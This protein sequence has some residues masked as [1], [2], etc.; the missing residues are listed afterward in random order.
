MGTIQEAV[1]PK[2]VSLETPTKN[3]LPK[4]ELPKDENKL[5]D[6]DDGL[7]TSI[8][9]FSIASEE[10]KE[11]PITTVWDHAIE[12]LFKPSSVYP[13]GSSLQMWVK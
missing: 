3:E 13:D 1:Q 11:T 4:V 8:P 12:T 7:I 6:E 10:E 5:S 9:D 2:E